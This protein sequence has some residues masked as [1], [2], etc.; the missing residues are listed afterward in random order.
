MEVIL[1]L[2]VVIFVLAIL[3]RAEFQFS[4]VIFIQRKNKHLYVDP[5]ETVH[6]TNPERCLGLCMHNDWCKAFNTNSTICEL[7]GN[8]RCVYGKPL[9]DSSNFNYFDT[10][11]DD[12]CPGKC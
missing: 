1:T 3:T 12:R 5:I 11:P 10:V 7:L 6:V 4:S 8:N 2:K 9:A